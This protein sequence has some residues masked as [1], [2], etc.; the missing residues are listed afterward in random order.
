MGDEINNN[1]PAAP[2]F[3]SET[4]VNLPANQPQAEYGSDLIA[5]LIGSLGHEYIFLTPGS[6]FR[7]VHD[8]RLPRAF[9]SLRLLLPSTSQ[10]CSAFRG[11][12]PRAFRLFCSN[13]K[14]S[15]LGT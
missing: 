9:G 14:S 5:E 6:S 3:I 13:D 1:Y 10:F 15:R 4:P 8:S 2:D 11:R 12:L 7:G